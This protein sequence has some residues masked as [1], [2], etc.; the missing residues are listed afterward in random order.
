MEWLSDGEE[1]SI[2]IRILDENDNKPEFLTVEN[3][4]RVSI[5]S[6]RQRGDMVAKIE[7]MS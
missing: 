4:I 6:D 3:P 7:V 5:A 2:T 1:I